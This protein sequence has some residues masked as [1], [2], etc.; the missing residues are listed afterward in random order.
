MPRFRCCMCVSKLARL[1]V[2]SGGTYASG[3]R[4]RTAVYSYVLFCSGGGGAACLT[5]E[6]LVLRVCFGM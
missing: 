4:D 3:P 5:K 6:L 1:D 2:L